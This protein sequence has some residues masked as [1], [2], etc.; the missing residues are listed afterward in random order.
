MYGFR[1]VHRCVKVKCVCVCRCVWH[2]EGMC[3]DCVFEGSTCV[4]SVPM[5]D[6]VSMGLWV[7]LRGV[8]VG[9]GCTYGLYVSG[10]ID[11]SGF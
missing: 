5:T 11:V 1:G 2:G 7:C 4:A 10:G 9:Y 3:G 6:C 8:E